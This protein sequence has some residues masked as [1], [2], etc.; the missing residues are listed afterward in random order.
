MVTLS[1]GW[2]CYTGVSWMGHPFFN[3]GNIAHFSRLGSS[4]AISHLKV[5]TSR[6]RKMSI[7][8]L[9]RFIPMQVLPP[10]PNTKKLYGRF[11]ISSS[12]NLEGS[13]MVGFS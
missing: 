12:L 8:I 10:A 9:A 4:S 11:I 1:S 5:V 3:L 2:H 13:N 6:C 7:M